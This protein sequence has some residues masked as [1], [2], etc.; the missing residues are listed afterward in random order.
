MDKLYIYGG[1]GH[2]LVVS[3]IAKAC[4]YKE[5][6]YIDDDDKNNH[7]SFENVKKKQAYTP[8]FWSWE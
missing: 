2:G 8:Y 1:G 6:I 3:D 4:G 7:M 5:I